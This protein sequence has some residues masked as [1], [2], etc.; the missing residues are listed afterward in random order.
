MRKAHL[1]IVS[2]QIFP[3]RARHLQ[4]IVLTHVRILVQT[5]VAIIQAALAIQDLVFIKLGKIV[6][7]LE[8]YPNVEAFDVAMKI[9]PYL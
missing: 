6:V 1:N 9:I 3:L 5:H 8:T 7:L 2:A 4:L